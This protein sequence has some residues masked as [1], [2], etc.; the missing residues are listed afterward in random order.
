MEMAGMPM[1]L[2]ASTNRMCI[3]KQS[4]DDALVPKNDDCKVTE[5]RRSGNTLRYKMV[6]SGKDPMTGEGEIT[7]TKDA[8]SGRMRMTGRMDGE[9]MDMT[10]TFSGRRL[11]ECTGTVQTQMARM[12][13]QGEAE[14]A[15]VCREGAQKLVVELFQPGG[16]CEAKKSQFCAE[17]STAAATAR[18]PAGH[19]ALRAR[20]PNAAAAFA[21][22]KQDYA[23]VT[24]VACGRASETRNF[25]FIAGGACDDE[26][27]RLGSVSCRGRSFTSI[28]ESMRGVCARYASITRGQPTASAAAS[29]QPVAA[30]KAADPVSQGVDAV[31]KL[32]P[33]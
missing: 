33:F 6:C 23:A 20:N 28:D 2:P 10:Q 16:A 5:T 8:Y 19:T 4:G 14:L 21:A 32:L 30:P 11:G 25:E 7:Q 15:K 27:R 29:P 31:R 22:C 9:P 24:R 13:A 1:A 26:V 12:Q 17:V 3:G 18:E